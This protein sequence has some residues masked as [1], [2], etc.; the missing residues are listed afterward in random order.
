[1]LNLTIVNDWHQ[2][3]VDGQVA[4]LVLTLLIYHDHLA[5][6]YYKCSQINNCYLFIFLIFF[7]FCVD[8]PL[9]IQVMDT[10]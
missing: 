1:V 7:L 3:L 6:S 5:F 10:A 4:G 8:T 2:W 9:N